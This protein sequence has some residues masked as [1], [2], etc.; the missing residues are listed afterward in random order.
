MN[1]GRQKM[2]LRYTRNETKQKQNF[3]FI[4]NTITQKD[5]R[6]L[7]SNA[8]FDDETIPFASYIVENALY[9]KLF[10]VRDFGSFNEKKTKNALRW[11]LDVAF[12]GYDKFAI[13]D[14]ETY[15]NICDA[16]YTRELEKRQKQ[17]DAQI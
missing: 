17:L 3:D 15:N 9:N 8:G 4:Y 16:Y 10:H 7:A 2:V 14:N 11:I 6:L 12:N 5:F 13:I 1:N